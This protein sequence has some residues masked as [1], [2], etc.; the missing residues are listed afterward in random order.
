MQPLLALGQPQA[1]LSVLPLNVVQGVFLHGLYQV[2]HVPDLPI[3]APKKGQPLSQC[4]IEHHLADTCERTSLT[5]AAI[6]DK[7]L[8]VALSGQE[9]GLLFDVMFDERDF[10]MT[11]REL[12]S[13]MV[14]P[15]V[16]VALIDRQ[17]FLLK[18]HPAR[19]LLNSLAEAV[20]G[21]RGEGAQERGRRCHARLDPVLILRSVFII[22]N[23]YRVHGIG[24]SRSRSRRSS[25]ARS[26]P[27]S[28]SCCL[29]Q[30]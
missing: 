26:L 22:K 1:K 25:C 24:S 3:V 27:S 30:P 11:A 7:A 8:F 12:M 23:G 18:N 17:L 20:E 6:V 13:K 21:N 14:V 4:F 10:E 5:V 2:P 9:V 16:K 28:V 15:Y 29:S 19:R